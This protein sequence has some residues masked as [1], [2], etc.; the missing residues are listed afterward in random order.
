MDMFVS[1]KRWKNS[2]SRFGLVCYKRKEEALEA[3]K[4]LNGIKKKGR[5]LEVS[6][7]KYDR[8]GKIWDSQISQEGE[9]V[10]GSQGEAKSLREIL[11]DGR[12]Y[13]DVVRGTSQ[14]NN[15][16]NK[17]VKGVHKPQS[18]R[19]LWCKGTLHKGP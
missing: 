14:N 5:V 3:V 19:P 8:N 1:H 13:R 12:S 9:D 6:V 2:D 18:L 11:K 4:N 16:S 10:A 7:A 15:G 17:V